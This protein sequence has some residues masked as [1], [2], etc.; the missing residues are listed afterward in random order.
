MESSNITLKTAE[1]TA[2]SASSHE[3]A[4][5]LL[6]VNSVFTGFTFE[7]DSAGRLL[8]WNGTPGFGECKSSANNT[9]LPTI[10]LSQSY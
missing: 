6:E 2:F 5:K 3:L 9:H 1:K 8:V 10:A 4:R 7:T